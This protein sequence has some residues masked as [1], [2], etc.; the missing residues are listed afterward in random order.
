MGEEHGDTFLTDPR[1]SLA[2]MI[3]TYIVG[4]IGLAIGVSS[5]NRDPAELSMSCLL[6]VGAV[7]VMSFVRHALLH[8]SDAARMGWD[9]GRRNNFQIEVG[10]ANLAIG[11][12]ALLAV[13]LDWGLAVESATFL[14]L[15]VYIAAVSVLKVSSS[16]ER[17]ERRR[18]IVSSAAFGAVLLY[19]GVVG[20]S[21][22]T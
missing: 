11:V 20:M 19:V 13:I 10:I 2:V 17:R 22:A 9:Y 21:A 5:V 4:G 16:V 3:A 8:R 7:G 6:A 15:G 12:V 1:S 14:V 18:A